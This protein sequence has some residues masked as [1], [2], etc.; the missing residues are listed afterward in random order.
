MRTFIYATLLTL[1][2]QPVSAQYLPSSK[3]ACDRYIFHFRLNMNRL[4]VEL[5][6]DQLTKT[7]D[8]EFTQE[9]HF[10]RETAADWAAIYNMWCKK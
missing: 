10:F 6:K 8:E 7:E 5:D 4:Q 3:D 2:A 9:Q 1:L